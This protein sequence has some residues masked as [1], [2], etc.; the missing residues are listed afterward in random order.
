M[1]RRLRYISFESGLQDEDYTLLPESRRDYVD[2][3]AC[4]YI[5]TQKMHV[6]P[7]AIWLVFI[8]Y[9]AVVFNVIRKQ[10]R[11]ILLEYKA[12]M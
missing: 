2:L 4:H 12:G 1:A 5:S 10:I 8:A 11:Y 3:C 6:H 9:T 7:I